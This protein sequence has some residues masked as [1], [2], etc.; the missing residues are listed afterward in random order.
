MH[1]L[2]LASDYDGTLAQHGRVSSKTIDALQRFR[3]SGRHLLL[4]TGRMLPDIQHAFPPLDLFAYVVTE[5]GAQLYEP[6]SST[7]TLLG[8]PPP[9]S[10]IHALQDRDIPFSTGEVI[11]ATSEPYEAA[12]LAIIRGLGLDL[13]VILNKGA[14]MILPT[15]IDKGTA[16]LTT[17]RK[18]QIPTRAVIGVGDAENDLSFMD[19]CGYSVAVA[20]ALPG[21][22]AAADH[23]TQAERGEGVTEL[24]EQVLSDTLPAPK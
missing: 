15:G 18:L 24:I 7:Q 10:F 19:R 13:H 21:L 9:A 11:V 22:R 2:A 20:N 12:V 14:V 16:L 23:I 8:E 4:I 6:A 1:Y 17:L 5:N 3:D